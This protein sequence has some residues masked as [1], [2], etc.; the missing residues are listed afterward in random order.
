MAIFEFFPRGIQK[1]PRPKPQGKH[2][3]SGMKLCVYF[4]DLIDHDRDD[5]E[6]VTNDTIISNIKD[7]CI[8]VFVDCYD[9]I[10]T[11]DT[12]SMLD[13]TGN[14]TSDVQLRTY[15]LTCLA[16][17]MCTWNP[18]FINSCTGSTYCCPKYIC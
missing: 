18:T 7:R 8:W 2:N 11:R 4:L 9:A 17:L 16:Y 10:R 3:T 15:S 5:S 6:Q 12:S 13:S 1:A 14:T